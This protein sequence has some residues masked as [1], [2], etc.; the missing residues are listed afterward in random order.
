MNSL[1]K[2][3]AATKHFGAL[4]QP[5]YI[6]STNAKIFEETELAYLEKEERNLFLVVRVLKS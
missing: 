6:T 1:K 3:F 5:N 2:L 4:D